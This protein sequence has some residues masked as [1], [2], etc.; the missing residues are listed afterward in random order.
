MLAER[1]KEREKHNEKRQDVLGEFVGSG[2]ATVDLCISS[3]AFRARV[4]GSSEPDGDGLT[5]L[6]CCT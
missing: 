2:L 4:Y 1:V 6:Y 5:S 3:R